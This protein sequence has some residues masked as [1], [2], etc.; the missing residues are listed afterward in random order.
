V[1]H[2]TKVEADEFFDAL[3]GTVSGLD[4]DINPTAVITAGSPAVG[5]IVNDDSATLT[6]AGLIASQDEG[7]GG[8]TTNITFIV[9]PDNA[10]QGGL[11]L[12]YTTD[13]DT[14]ATADGDYV[15]NNG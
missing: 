3:L 9:T 15:D 2:D 7:T 12:A 5:T 13:D 8:T 4:R 10:I 11:D 1:I 14:A 6:L